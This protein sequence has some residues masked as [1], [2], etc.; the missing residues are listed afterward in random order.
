[1]KNNIHLTP[2][3]YLWWIKRINI[4]ENVLFIVSDIY[5]AHH[6]SSVCS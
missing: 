5:T 2:L 1:M 3:F 6:F 4:I